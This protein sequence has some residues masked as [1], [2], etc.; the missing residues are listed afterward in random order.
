MSQTR[1]PRCHPGRRCGGLIA[2]DGT[3]EEGAHERLQAHL[4]ELVNPK[5]GK[6]RPN[7]KQYRRRFLAEFPSSRN[8]NP[9]SARN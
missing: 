7:R 2:S 5:V 4:R 1:G 9:L 6:H 8:G 3:G